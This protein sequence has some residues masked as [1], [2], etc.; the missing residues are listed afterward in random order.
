MVTSNVGK[1]I[2]NEMPFLRVKVTGEIIIIRID[3]PGV[4]K[5]LPY[6]LTSNSNDVVDSG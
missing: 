3:A 6:S 1:T 4:S 2:K 5:C